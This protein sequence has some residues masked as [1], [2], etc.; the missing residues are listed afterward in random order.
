LYPR[1]YKSFTNR[2]LFTLRTDYT[3]PLLY[4]DWNLGRWIYLKRINLRGFYDYG[5]T[6]ALAS[7][8]NQR[9]NYNFSFKS[10]GAEVTTNCH[11]LRFKAPANLGVR[12]SYMPD[13]NDYRLDVLF[14]VNFS[15]L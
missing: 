7:Q 15:A 12:Y 14:S 6:E 5:W 8:N 3:L 1:G 2:Q 4:P 11:F 10:Y 9:I 13:L